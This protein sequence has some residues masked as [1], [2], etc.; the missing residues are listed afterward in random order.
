MGEASA[1]SR[2]RAAVLANESRCIYCANPPATL[3]HMPPRSMFLSKSR[4]SGFE[5]AACRACNE[6][7]SP[8]D[9]VA[10]FFARLN[11][12]YG[13]DRRLTIEARERRDRVAASAPGVL[14]ELFRPDK[15]K[16]VWSRN[17]GPVATPLLQIKVDGPATRA[18]LTVFAAKLG[19]A[20]YREHVGDALP[21]TGG[22][23]VN[24]FLNAG[25]AQATA[26]DILRILPTPGTLR[27]GAFQVYVDNMGRRGSIS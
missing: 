2:S 13:G 5:F 12:S 17:A 26:E 22:V 24:W 25:L 15:R 6:A 3:E 19:M 23:H 1:R 7:T 11:N 4:P 20:F 10:S 8:A 9:L 18:Y 27:Q 14:E 16:P 21:L